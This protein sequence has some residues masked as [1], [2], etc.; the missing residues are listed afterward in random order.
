MNAY[1]ESFDPANGESIGQVAITPVSTLPDILANAKRAAHTWQRLSLTERMEIVRDAFALIL[2]RAEELAVLLSQEMGKDIRRSRSEVAGI[3]YGASYTAEEAAEALATRKLNANTQLQ[4]AP[5][6]VAAVI[7]PWNYPLAMAGNLIVPALIAG[8]TVI[9]KPSEETP[10]VAQAM[11]DIVKQ[12]LPEHVLQIVQGDETLGKALVKSDISLIAFTGSVAAGKHIMAS[13]ADG[14]KR[15]IMELGGNDPMIVMNDANVEVAARFAVASSLENSGQMCTS[16][17][18]IYVD[19]SVADAFIRRVISIAS[20]YKA[21]PWHQDGVNLGPLVNHRQHAHVMHHIQDA[22]AKGATL[23]LGSPEQA[24][25]YITPTVITGMTPDMMLEQ[26]ETFG[27]VVAIATF[28]ELS[29]AVARANNSDYG[30]GAV[31]FGGNG[32]NQVAE[33]MEAG[34]VAINEGVGGTG[35]SPWVGAK[36]SGYGFHGSVDGHRQFAQVKVLSRRR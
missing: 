14:L 33:Q 9:F 24:P 32:A 28:D 1:L 17:E 2:P 22:L 5:L 15:L 30:L 6:G 29:D 10:L 26:D 31:V 16:T 34:M 18:R 36:Q 7:S 13:A 19:S 27:P 3:A 8:N 4:Y 21:G 20:R 35:D 11:V 12:A 25:P 23:E